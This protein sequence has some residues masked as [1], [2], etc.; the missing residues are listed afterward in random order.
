MELHAAFKMPGGDTEEGDTITVLGI[1][2]G[3]N[4]KHKT[5]D[6]VFVRR[7]FAFGRL[8]RLWARGHSDQTVQ[9]LANGNL[10][11]TNC[12]GDPAQ[13]QAVEVTA[14]SEIVWSFRDVQHFGSG[15]SNLVVIE[16]ER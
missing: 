12:N 5:A 7:H 16:A 8:H 13:P 10:V 14:S 4:F 9:E 2:I 3:L 1:H 6:F 15:L 11:L